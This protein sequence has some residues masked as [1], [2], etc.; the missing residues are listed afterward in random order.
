LVTGF[1]NL[2]LD[3]LGSTV[4]SKENLNDDL[5]DGS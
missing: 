2:K 3:L 1:G 4:Y 5:D